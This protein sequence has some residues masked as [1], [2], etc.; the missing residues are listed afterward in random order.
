VGGIEVLAVKR[1]VLAHHDGVELLRSAAHF[2]RL[3]RSE[4]VRCSAA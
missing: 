3:G 2:G 1:R 4:P